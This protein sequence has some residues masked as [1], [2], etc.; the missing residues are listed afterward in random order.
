AETDNV[1]KKAR[2]EGC[3][4]ALGAYRSDAL[5]NLICGGGAK[6]DTH[7]VI[8][9]EES[10]LRGE[11]GLCEAGGAPVPVSEAIGAML[12]R[13]F[14][15]IVTHRGVDVTQVVHHGR[16]IPAELKTAIFERD[17]YTCVRPGCGAT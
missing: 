10:R 2:A 5:V 7:V 17:G 14:V 12:A 11:G 13:A 1:F 16:H 6:V 4:E 3:T 9:V 8:R 15:K